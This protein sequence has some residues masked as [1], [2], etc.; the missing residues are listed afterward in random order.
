[1]RHPESGESRH[2]T[3]NIAMR[4]PYTEPVSSVTE[5]IRVRRGGELNELDRTLL[6][7][8][9]VAAGWNILFSAIRTATS[10]PAHLRELAICRIAALNGAWFEWKHHYPL[11]LEAG[12]DDTLMQLVKRGNQWDLSGMEDMECGT[13]RWTVLRYVDCMTLN[14][15]VPQALFDDLRPWMDDKGIVELTAIV[16]SYNMVS[17]FLVA[18]DVGEMNKGG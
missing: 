2:P 13:L 11:A 16:A 8:L 3:Q 9:P 6:H 12:V 7:S 14:V 10:I 1:L 4:L 15:Q 5:A 17:R 18:L